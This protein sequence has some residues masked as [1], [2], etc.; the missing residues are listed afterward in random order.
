MRFAG[1]QL[2]SVIKM[3]ESQGNWKRLE[4]STCDITEG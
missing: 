3:G 4:I 1:T 2:G